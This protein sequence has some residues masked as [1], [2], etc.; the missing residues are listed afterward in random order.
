[1]EKKYKFDDSRTIGAI[2]MT[3]NTNN[4]HK[5][6]CTEMISV[7]VQYRTMIGDLDCQFVNAQITQL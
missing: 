5:T 2:V 4:H 3:G 1:M 6:T 7:P